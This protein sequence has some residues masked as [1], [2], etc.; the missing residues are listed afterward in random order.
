M[1]KP[2]QPNLTKTCVSC[3]QQKPLS[4]FLE[5]SGTQGTAY[6]NV[7]ASCRKTALE[8]MERRR[9]TEAEGSTTSETGHKIDSKTKIHESVTKREEFQQTEEEYHKE[10]DINETVSVEVTEKKQQA[11][12]K[13][14]KHRED[15]L[16]RPIKPSDKKTEAAK[17]ASQKFASETHARYIQQNLAADL[18]KHGSFEESKKTQHDFSVPYQGQQM[19]GQIR[20][21]G[22]I[23]Q[24][25][26]QWLGN[27]AP[28]VNN[29]NITQKQA[30][31]KQAGAITESVT[32]VKDTVAAADKAEA[33][34]D[35]AIDFIEKN[36]RPGSKR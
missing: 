6:G 34:K 8:E 26:R 7:C 17:A 25:F 20:F 33:S 22:A 16:H 9:K 4:A 23:F 36:F 31:P 35:P 14:K 27:S 29:V 13:E 21:S 3:G 1:N 11:A 32:N 2:A 19:G 15:F 30:A 24:Q 28:V 12:Q 18:E 5:M 10:R